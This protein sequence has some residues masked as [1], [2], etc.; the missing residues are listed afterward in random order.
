ME[1]TTKRIHCY[2]DDAQKVLQWI[3]VLFTRKQKSLKKIFFKSR[4]DCK[5]DRCIRIH[6]CLIQSELWLRKKHTHTPIRIKL[7]SKNF[8]LNILLRIA[9]QRKTSMWCNM[10]EG[11][12]FRILYYLAANFVMRQNI[13]EEIGGIVRNWT[14]KSKTSGRKEHIKVTNYRFL[15]KRQKNL[16]KYSNASSAVPWNTLLPACIKMMCEKHWNMSDVGWWIEQMMAF[17][18]ALF[19]LFLAISSKLLS[20]AESFSNTNRSKLGESSA[21]DSDKY[22]NALITVRALKLSNPVVGSSQNIIG[23]FVRS[24]IKKILVLVLCLYHTHAHFLY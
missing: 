17:G 22:F 1:S 24:W 16:E 8:H 5:K 9:V 23:G 15:I 3:S 2:K 4:F 6:T 11:S 19:F 20:D 18:A 13:D 12:I 10:F 7:I 21:W 14:I